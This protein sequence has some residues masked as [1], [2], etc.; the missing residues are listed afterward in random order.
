MRDLE[1]SGGMLVVF[2]APSG[3]GKTSLLF[4]VLKKHPEFQF[5]VSATTRTPRPGES[6]GVNYN[7]LSH[8]EFDNLIRQGELLEWN[9]VYGNRYGTLKRTVEDGLMQGNNIIFDTDTVGAFNIRK[10]FPE[11][12][13]IFILPPSPQVLY[14]RLRN[15]HTESPEVIEERLKV[16]PEEIAR[17][18][19]YD[20][21]IINDDFDRALSQVEAIIEAE[22]A[23]SSRVIPT[24][25]EWRNY[26]YG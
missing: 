20:Y 24:L 15:R 25:N 10:H 8:E 16:V 5:S 23:R 17:M 6:D 21:I 2:T 19:E 13:L 3:A 1:N 11:A 22:K 26:M 18:A 12:I 9:E 14:E 4:E 7:F